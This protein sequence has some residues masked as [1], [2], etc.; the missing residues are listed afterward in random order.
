[1]MS[2]FKI[3]RKENISRRYLKQNRIFLKIVYDKKRKFENK[4]IW[5]REGKAKEN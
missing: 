2:G 4:R 1:M 3:E 5:W